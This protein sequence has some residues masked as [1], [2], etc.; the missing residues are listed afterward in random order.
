MILTLNM[1]SDL[2]IYQQIRNQIVLALAT[3]QLKPGESLPSVRQLADDI[4]VNMMTVSKA[5]QSLKEEGVVEMDRRQGTKIKEHI[6]T[7]PNYLVELTETLELLFAQATLNGIS[8]T[9]INDLTKKIYL[10]HQR[11]DV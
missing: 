5:Y 7:N 9:T 4:G 10:T 8:E 1:T 3:G 2:P 11:K 6:S